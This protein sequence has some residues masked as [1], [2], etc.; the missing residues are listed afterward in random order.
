MEENQTGREAKIKRCLCKRTNKDI[1]STGSR[2]P[3]TKIK[4]HNHKTSRENPQPCLIQGKETLQ[5][6]DREPVSPSKKWRKTKNTQKEFQRGRKKVHKMTQNFSCE[7]ISLMG[8]TKIN[9]RTTDDL[10]NF[11]EVMQR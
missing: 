6:G 5:M 11:K 1:K 8:S 7:S 4:G 3:H 2:T 10:L 9:S